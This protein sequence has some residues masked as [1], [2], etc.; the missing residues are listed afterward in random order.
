[1]LYRGNNRG[2]QSWMWRVFHIGGANTVICKSH[3]NVMGKNKVSFMKNC[4]SHFNVMG[5]NKVSFMKNLTTRINH[6]NFVTITPVNC[7][8]KFH[9]VYG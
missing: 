4:K 5:K 1:M 3:F 7:S 9:V 2:Q 6:L 8:F